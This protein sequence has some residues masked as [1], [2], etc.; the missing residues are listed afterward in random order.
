METN[1]STAHSGSRLEKVS[2]RSRPIVKEIYISSFPKEERMPF[3]LMLLMGKLWNTKYPK[4]W[5]DKE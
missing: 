2:G 1:I 5:R 3:W 4:F